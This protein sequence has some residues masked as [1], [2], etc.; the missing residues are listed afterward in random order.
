MRMG[1]KWLEKYNRK[2]I[3]AKYR[4]GV[5]DD[6]SGEGGKKHSAILQD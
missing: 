4:D 2:R 5:I 3:L 6:M 1:E